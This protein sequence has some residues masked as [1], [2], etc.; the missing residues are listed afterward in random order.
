M[1]DLDKLPEWVQVLLYYLVQLL[2]WLAF[3]LLL[4]EFWTEGYK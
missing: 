3:W 4:L 2:F 1:I